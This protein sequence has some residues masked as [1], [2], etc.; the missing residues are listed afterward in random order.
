MTLGIDRLGLLLHD[1]TR[2]V[3]RRFELRTQDWGLSSAQWRLLVSLKR[4][5][6]A[7]QARLA[8]LLEI[9][10][11]SVS[12]MVDRMEQTGW[13]RREPDPADRR[14]KVIVPT[15]RALKAFET[16]HGV[17][18][19]VYAEA[20]AGLSD[21]EKAALVKAL[22]IIIENL[23]GEEAACAAR[24]RPDAEST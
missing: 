10:P 21:P 8:E 1:A 18:G 6:R 12:R 23:T 5:A 9:E 15:E 20:L 24:T 16:V 2:A 11:I 7:S 13:V 14:V 4:D 17:A 22:N 19:E 3:R